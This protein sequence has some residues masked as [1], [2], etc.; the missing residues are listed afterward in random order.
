MPGVGV[1]VI[2]TEHGIR[3][4]TGV[5]MFCQKCSR[6]RNATDCKLMPEAGLWA[7]CSAKKALEAKVHH[8]EAR[9]VEHIF[10]E[11]RLSLR[12]AHFPKISLSF[13]PEALDSCSQSR[14]GRQFS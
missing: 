12:C 8:F 4:A 1:G 2:K 10:M 14:R 3:K 7:S 13:Q 6:L 5:V 11:M 9:D